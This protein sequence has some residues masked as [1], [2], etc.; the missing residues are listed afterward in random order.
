MAFLR[1]AGVRARRYGG[2]PSHGGGAH[3]CKA[4]C[5]LHVG[6]H[7][8][9]DLDAPDLNVRPGPA[10]AANCKE[11]L[12]RES[13]DERFAAGSSARSMPVHG[14]PQ[15]RR[16]TVARVATAPLR[17]QLSA[18]LRDELL[19]EVAKL[20]ENDEAAQWARRALAA[21]NSLSDTHA[22]QVEEAFELKLANFRAAV[23]QADAPDTS[24]PEPVAAERQSVP[25]PGSGPSEIVSVRPA[26]TP[27][28]GRRQQASRKR[29]SRKRRPSQEVDASNLTLDGAVPFAVTD[30]EEAVA[31]DARV[32]RINKADL[33]LSEPRATATAITSSS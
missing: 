31:Q 11:G 10:G 18:V 27:D 15:A 29:Q 24:E 20:R 22:R 25:F 4:L 30:G 32:P 6:W 16:S 33:S 5:A 9:R 26:S 13:D 21:K 14:V 17:D 2:A 8:R 23:D 28:E 19:G 7:C 3:L 12:A 1:L